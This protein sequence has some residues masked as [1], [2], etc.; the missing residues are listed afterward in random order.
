M[1]AEEWEWRSETR[2]SF[3]MKGLLAIVAVLVGVYF[4]AN[5]PHVSTLPDA[6]NEEVDTTKGQVLDAAL[7]GEPPP[8]FQDSIKQLRSANARSREVVLE[9]AIAR[10]T[11]AKRKCEHEAERLGKSSGVWCAGISQGRGRSCLFVTRPRRWK[12]LRLFTYFLRCP[13]S[14]HAQ[15]QRRRLFLNGIN[16]SPTEATPCAIALEDTR[17]SQG[18]SDPVGFREPLLPVS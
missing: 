4:L 17:A 16:V 15:A 14:D 11:D 13:R 1:A 7:Q 12:T 8:L 6:H 18:I 9:L 2:V 5:A 3:T 10:A